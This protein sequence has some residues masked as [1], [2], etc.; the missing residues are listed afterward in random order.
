MRNK[1]PK[2]R[3]DGQVLKT[4]QTK[5]GDYKMRIPPLNVHCCNPVLMPINTRT[6]RQG[7]RMRR[8]REEAG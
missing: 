4:K 7:K 5:E 8:G 2:S 1:N 3:T 6:A